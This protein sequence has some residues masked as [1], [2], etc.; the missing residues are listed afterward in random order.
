MTSCDLL[1]RG[2]DVIDGTGRSAF[3]ADLALEGGRIAAVAPPGELAAVQ[4][5]ATLD[6]SGKVLTP[7][8]ID[9]HSHSDWLVPGKNAAELVE[10]FIRQGMTSIVGGNCGFSPAPIS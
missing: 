6:V 8:F 10:P 2:G 1:L 3:R 5:R 9:I 7:G 4:A